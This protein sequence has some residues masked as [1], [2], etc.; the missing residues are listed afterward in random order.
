[1]V[2]DPTKN[3]MVEV[4]MGEKLRNLQVMIGEQM[5]QIYPEVFESLDS[6]RAFNITL[7]KNKQ[8][9]FTDEDVIDETFQDHDKIFFEIDSINFWLRVKFL[10][11]QRQSFV[12][13]AGDDEKLYIEGFTRIRVNKH[14][15]IQLL[16]KQLQLLIFQVWFLLIG[17]DNK[18]YMLDQFSVASLFPP[19]HQSNTQQDSSSTGTHGGVAK[20]DAPPAGIFRI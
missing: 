13:T 7:E 1:M 19:A 14:E 6:V 3:I 20:S 15:T 10:L 17:E 18:Y 8:R 12:E 11:Y 2:T 5:K 9:Q 16:R 4:K